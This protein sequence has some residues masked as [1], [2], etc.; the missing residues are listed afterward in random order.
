M[1]KRVMLQNWRSHKHTELE[2]GKG[3]NVLIGRMGAGKSSVVNAICF[4]LFGTFPELQRREA[5]LDNIIMN[6]P[7][8]QDSARVELEFL[9]QG[10]NYKIERIINAGSKTNEAKLYREGKI[11]AGPK[12][13]DV[14]RRVEEILNV[15]YE[16]FSRAIYAEQNQ[17]DYLLKLSPSERKTK[18][19]QLLD[20]ERYET[21]RRNAVTL[22][23]SIRA[24]LEER[25]ASLSEQKAMFSER[26]LKEL[27]K[28]ISGF[29]EAVESKK[30]ELKDAKAKLEDIEEKMKSMIE[31]QQKYNFLRNKIASLNGSISMLREQIGKMSKT[32]GKEIKVENK[33]KASG[34]V[35]AIENELD[36][37]SRAENE[38]N[39]IRARI[40]ENRAKLARIEYENGRL[41]SALPADAKNAEKI[42][43]KIKQVEEKIEDAK[44]KREELKKKRAGYE[45]ELTKVRKKVAVAKDRIAEAQETIEKLKKAKAVCP[46][47]KQAL[48]E[49][50]RQKIL[51]EL[52]NSIASNRADLKNLQDS[53]K[54]LIK[55]ISACE[56]E[57]EAL[58]KE[59]NELIEIKAHIL[60]LGEKIGQAERNSRQAETIKK[61]IVE[62]EHKE[63]GL[64]DVKTRIE[65]RR[66]E[67]ENAHSEL[68]G[69]ERAE[70]LQKNLIALDQYK[71]ELS[72]LAFDEESAADAK[73]EF[74][75]A[76]AKVKT[77][78]ME[79]ES[80]TGIMKEKK[81][82]LQ[83]ALKRKQ[84]IE[85]IGKKIE[86]MEKTTEKLG[87][88]ITALKATQ[89]EL[90]NALIDTINQAMNELWSKV[91][92]YSDYTGLKLMTNNAYELV[93]RTNSAWVPIEGTLSGGERS[94]AA[95]VLRIA[96]SFVLARNIN[97]LILD[98]PTHNLDERTISVL[99]DMVKNVLPEFVEQIFLI[100]HDK[101]M[102]KAASSTLYL[103]K[104]DKMENGVTKKEL[105]S[106]RT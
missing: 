98:E 12:V 78:E 18:F 49:Q 26:E 67:L 57:Q 81:V 102:E 17:I 31:K 99:A 95:L 55:N 28:Q 25:K 76:R 9:H 65:K 105:L 45:E 10:N 87:L 75:R 54:E 23:N 72:E 92:P 13:S 61:E 42:A 4:A 6:R 19:D 96:T 30:R 34:R 48:T 51:K 27:Q 104:R 70:V 89:S 77:I 44:R 14:N 46:T 60:Q 90:R 29:E 39:E 24:L 71:K 15:E 100:T 50:H 66:K 97:M 47:C 69:I 74:E 86:H 79:I 56:R 88:F 91:Y 84:L 11:I 35:K 83:E 85:S 59:Q 5:S 62:L 64:A 37:L 63:K 38:L 2:F 16:L 36:A 94:V 103:L 101:E 68:E 41:L 22:R 58:A 53:E 20:L 1:I 43:E 80:K 3:S 8:K 40:R 52:E 93:V 82:R 32:L 7:L 33:E 106:L 73:A 21:V